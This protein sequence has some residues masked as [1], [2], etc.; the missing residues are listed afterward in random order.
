MATFK[1]VFSTTTKV[2]LSILVISLVLGLVILIFYSIGS[3]G[4]TSSSAGLSNP[5]VEY[6]NADDAPTTMPKSQWDW[7]IESSLEVGTIV[8]GM[9]K[10]QVE[11]ILRKPSSSR[12]TSH[13]MGG[14]T[15][16]Y[17]YVKKKGECR[18]YEGENCAEYAPNEIENK[19]LY[20]SPKGNLT[21]GGDFFGFKS[22]DITY[23]ISQE[24]CAR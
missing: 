6:K 10:S 11:Q 23:K 20:F 15:W 13:G 14:E 17:T 2:L 8:E 12:P 1:E 5:E 7:M 19:T 16:I 4:S 21:T 22:C 3:Q 24:N 9:S 18:K